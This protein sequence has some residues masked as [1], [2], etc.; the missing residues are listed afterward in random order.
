M[1]KETTKTPIAKSKRKDVIDVKK[2][3]KVSALIKFWNS[4]KIMSSI[5]K[6]EESPG[7]VSS[8]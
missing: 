7:K 6:F 2:L 8:I 4:L 3:V 1:I 5:L